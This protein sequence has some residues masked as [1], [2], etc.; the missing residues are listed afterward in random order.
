MDI[1][2]LYE[3]KDIIV[4]IKEPGVSVQA[5]KSRSKDMVNMLRNYVVESE[6]GYTKE[7]GI[8][9]IGL[10]H[11]LDRPV[12][13]VMVFAKTSIALKRLNSQMVNGGISKRY[14]A[15][16]SDSSVENDKIE[17]LEKEWTKLEDYLIKDG[18]N[19][20]SKVVA[21]TQKDAKKAILEYKPIAQ[22]KGMILNDIKLYT[23]RHHQIRVQMSHHSM[24]LVGDAK[25]NATCLRGDVML[26]S[27]RLEFKHP[28]LGKD[29]MFENI[30]NNGEFSYFNEV[31][32]K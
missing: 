30:P 2:I 18:R 7:Q 6:H 28:T 10:V 32:A 8:P 22:G 25:Y 31:L 20:V 1:K 21:K 3:D 12:G 4:C 9:N 27:Y 19:N 24:P 13:G 11:R 15:I 23:G 17:L 16:T 14:F 29:M 5:D 26:Y